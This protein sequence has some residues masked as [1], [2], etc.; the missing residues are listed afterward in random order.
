MCVRWCWVL[1]PLLRWPSGFYFADGFLVLKQPVFQGPWTSVVPVHPHCRPCFADVLLRSIAL[2]CTRAVVW[3]VFCNVARTRP[4]L[5]ASW[6]V[7]V[8]LVLSVP[9][10]VC[11]LVKPFFCF[12]FGWWLE[13]FSSFNELIHTCYL[14]LLHEPPCVVSLKQ[15]VH[16]VS[17]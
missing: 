12:F 9:Q 13:G 8:E 2:L 11:L 4:L 1:L 5:P 3:P 7:K 17:V 6:A 16:F 10:T 15:L 14:F